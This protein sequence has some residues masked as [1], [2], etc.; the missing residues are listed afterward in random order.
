M[1][2]DWRGKQQVCDKLYS[3]ELPESY[4]YWGA[5]LNDA[6][7]RFCLVEDSVL[8]IGCG[9]PSNSI[10]YLGGT[11][12]QYVGVD[13]FLTQF[14][15]PLLHLQGL[16]E[17][18]PFRSDCFNNVALISVLDHVLDPEPVIAEASRVL[19]KGGFLYVMIL[20]WTDHFSLERDE[21]HF[22][23]FTKQE[24]Y[25]L[26]PMNFAVKAVQFLPYKEDYRKVMFLKARKEG[27]LEDVPYSL[28]D[29]CGGLILEFG[30]TFKSIMGG[31]IISRT[32]CFNCNNERKQDGNV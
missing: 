13:P 5:I 26:I 15:T 23:H 19:R 25:R 28:C 9:D 14:Y 30:T 20:V 21:Y 12:F 2:E 4:R 1:W 10:K 17:N 29:E 31:T 24:I 11:G 32:L 27:E 6:F 16:G 18:L 8:D 3:N 22:K 7:S